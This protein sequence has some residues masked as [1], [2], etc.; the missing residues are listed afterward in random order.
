M[1][2]TLKEWEIKRL[3][4]L[5]LIL[6]IFTL[7]LTGC[8]SAVFEISPITIHPSY[9]IPGE[10]FTVNAEVTNVGD[11]DGVYDA[12]LSI[13]G[14]EVDTKTVPIISGATE[15]VS[16]TFTE[17]TPGS[18]NI[19]LND[20]TT[21]LEIPSADEIVDKVIQSMYEIDTYQYDMDMMISMSGVV[22]GESNDITIGLNTIGTVDNINKRLWSEIELEMTI[23]MPYVDRYDFNMEM[24]L[25]GNDMY[26][27]TESEEITPSWFKERQP[28]GSWDEMTTIDSQVAI[29]ETGEIKL[30]GSEKVRGKDCYVIN[31]IPDEEELLKHVLQ[32]TTFGGE[33]V[34]SITDSAVRE[35][36]KDAVLKQ[37]VDKE[38][39]FITNQEVIMGGTITPDMITGDGEGILT[40]DIT[41]S[42]L[43]YNHNKQV[44]IDIPK[45]AE[46]AFSLDGTGVSQAAETELANIQ[47]ATTALMVDNR[48]AMLP[49]PVT[50]AT[51]DMNAFPDAVSVVTVDKV[52][53]PTGTPYVAGDN[54]GF[55]LYQHDVTGGGDNTTLVN[56]VAT[57]TTQGTYTVDVM[58]TVTQV[59]TGY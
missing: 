35:L 55:V 46:E 12:V 33:Q 44:Y 5:P 26:F 34:P 31:V 1:L 56:Y 49:N 14:A 9:V 45:E 36:I 51:N 17:D 59:T 11:A 27:M 57:R 21:I 53:D 48:L 58:G 28:I 22:D 6:L 37:W 54:D 52:S 29:L 2:S 19:S 24:Y 32:E 50:I 38:T 39:L 3:L 16:F 18:Y 42:I 20:V 40:M 8:A 15:T 25:I 41:F 47:A 7:S 4:V 23:I 13:N 30:E 10:T 43:T